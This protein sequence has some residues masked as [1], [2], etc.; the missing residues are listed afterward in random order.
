M[1]PAEQPIVCLMGPTASGKTA[2]ALRLCDSMPFDIISVDSALVYRGMDIG[3]AKPSVATLKKY[4]HRLVDIRDPEETYSA[5]D[6]VRDARREIRLI[7]GAGRLP[8]LVGGTMMYFRALTDGMADLPPA[9]QALRNEIDAEAAELGWPEMHQQLAG[10]DPQAALKISPNDSHRI[11]RA[12]EVYRRSGV[13]LTEWQADQA[14]DGG[15][16]GTAIKI[17]LSGAP[18]SEIHARIGQRLARM[19]EEGLV[20]EVAGLRLR[21]S[22]TRDHASMRAVGYRQIWSHLEGEQSLVQA[23]ER[24]LVATRQLCKR[25]LTWL[26]SESDLMVVNPLEDEAFAAISTFLQER[27]AA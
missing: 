2:Y 9:D 27:L 26:R 8:L 25:Q 20:R 10:F 19:M 14:R 18:R 11:Q 15:A 21:P 16:T 22:L 4:P 12:T 24:A 13:S 7:R 17:S 3:T 23:T 6:F 5:G 1:A